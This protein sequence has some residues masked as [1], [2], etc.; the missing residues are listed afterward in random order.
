MGLKLF[1]KQLGVCHSDDLFY[2]FPFSLFV[3][4][5]PLKTDLDKVLD[6]FRRLF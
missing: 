4:P 6:R 5:R 3:F 2:V 1:Q